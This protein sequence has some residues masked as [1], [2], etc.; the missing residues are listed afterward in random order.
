MSLR[1]QVKAMRTNDGC[2]WTDLVPKRITIAQMTK[3][4]T[5][6]WRA[7]TRTRELTQPRKRDVHGKHEHCR[8]NKRERE[9]ERA[10]KRERVRVSE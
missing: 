6:T 1:A 8:W 4:R 7:T 5:P 10:R 2:V 3:L 9:K